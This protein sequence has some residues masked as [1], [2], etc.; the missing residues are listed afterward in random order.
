MW[1]LMGSRNWLVA[2]PPKPQNP[3]CKNPL[4]IERLYKIIHMY[5]KIFEGQK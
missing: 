4:K 3:M 1:L 2:D 5:F